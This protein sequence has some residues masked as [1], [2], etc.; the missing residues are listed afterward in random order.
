MHRLSKLILLTMVIVLSGCG[1]AGKVRQLLQEGTLSKNEYRV[2]LNFEERNGLLIVPVTIGG[3]VR[4]F[5]LDTGAPNLITSALASELGMQAGLTYKVGDAH[6]RAQPLSFVRVDSLRISDLTFYGTGAIVSDFSASPELEC[7]GVEGIIGA[8]LLAKTFLQIDYPNSKIVLA[9]HLDSLQI[10]TAALRWTFT[11]SAQRTPQVVLRANG[12]PLGPLTVD[13]G[14][15]GWMAAPKSA[16]ARVRDNGPLQVRRTYGSASIGLYGD[17][18]KDTLF[19]TWVTD[20]TMPDSTALLPAAIDFSA[21]STGQ[22]G[23]AYLRQFVLSF[24]WRTNQLYLSPSG[25]S[26]EKDLVTFG[27]NPLFRN[28]QLLVSLVWQDSQADR[29]GIRPGDRVLFMN[30]M[31]CINFDKK[32]YCRFLIDQQM[33][34]NWE[35]LDLLIEQGGTT[36]RIKLKKEPYFH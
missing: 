8:N 11:S 7:V 19:R 24:D 29:E 17:A 10:D 18:R 27:F 21:A 3:K 15:T 23:N 1:T 2:T 20:L 16:F 34:K 14:A 33:G 12:V 5:L 25:V 26:N 30:G 4:H 35:E 36:R 32:A 6:G 31:D 22:I 13:T 28:D 9:S